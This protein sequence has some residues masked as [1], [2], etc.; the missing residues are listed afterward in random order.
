MI[1]IYVISPPDRTDREMTV[2]LR[3][4]SYEAQCKTGGTLEAI[5]TICS[6]EVLA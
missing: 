4:P 2:L 1:L 3:I 6:L 5:C